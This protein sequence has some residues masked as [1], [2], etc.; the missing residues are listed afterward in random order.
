MSM[1]SAT[2]DHLEEGDV[3]RILDGEAGEEEAP[4]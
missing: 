1:E 2:T 3:I 4:E